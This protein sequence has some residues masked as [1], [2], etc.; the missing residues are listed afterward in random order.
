M[1]PRDPQRG[2][3]VRNVGFFG[4]RKN[5][6]PVFQSA[7]F[8][9][10]LA[11]R[12]LRLIIRE[13]DWED[14]RDIDVVLA[15]RTHLA[16]RIRAVKPPLKLLNAWR[17]GV[18]ALLGPEPGYRELRQ[19]PLDYI[20]IRT[21]QQA[22]AAL[23][24]FTRHPNTY[25]AIREH[26]WQRAAA[27]RDDEVTNDWIRFL[28]GPVAIAYERWRRFAWLKTPRRIVRAI[29]AARQQRRDYAAWWDQSQWFVD[30]PN[31]TEPDPTT[32]SERD[33]I[34]ALQSPAAAPLLTPM[35]AGV[36]RETGRE[37]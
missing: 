20:E 6:A 10:A 7:E 37:S 31:I 3:T 32:I 15:V 34:R 25:A 8:E 29:R 28:S 13:S 24:N 4:L 18:P 35:L 17:A 30:G 2:D 1:Q 16:A 33:K 9:A 11:E 19:D 14:Y 23:D 22:L 5:M 26:G 36:G 12:G 21:P 27:F